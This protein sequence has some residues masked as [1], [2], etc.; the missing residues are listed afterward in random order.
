MTGGHS[1]P[2]YMHH[3]YSSIRDSHQL[4]RQSRPSLFTS[5]GATHEYGTRHP[6]KSNHK[7]STCLSAEPENQ[8]A[9]TLPRNPSYA[10]KRKRHLYH[11]SISMSH[12]AQLCIKGFIIYEH[13]RFDASAETA[14]YPNFAVRLPCCSIQEASLGLVGSAAELLTVMCRIVAAAEPHRQSA[15]PQGET[16][17]PGQWTD[18]SGRGAPVM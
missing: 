3:L 6:S 1:E 18:C 16:E 4:P 15:A 5:A 9:P 10:A 13:S 14:V 12:K 8:A 7:L 2:R 11:T 17:S